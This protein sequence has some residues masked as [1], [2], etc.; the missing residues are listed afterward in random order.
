MRITNNMIQRDSLARLQS[1]IRDVASAQQQVS[2]GLR[3][4]RPSDDPA[5]ASE[6]MRAGGGL[7]VLQQY[8]RNIESA[9]SR[10]AA[11]EGVLDRLTEA[12][13]RAK[14]LGVQEGSGTANAQTRRVAKAEVD[15][16]LANAVSFG[17]TEFAG[18]YLF[19]GDVV[20]KPPFQSPVYSATTPPT[21][22]APGPRGAAQ[23]EIA[24]GQYV[25]ATHDGTQV[26]LDTGAILA[27][28]RLS[29]ALG[30][31]DETKIRQSLVDLDSA[32]SNVQTI[33]GETGARVNQL[34]VASANLDA[35]ETNLTTFKS[36]LEEVDMEKAMTE[37][38]GRQTAYQAAMMATSRVLG[39]NLADYLR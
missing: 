7:R 27:L 8:R 10:A 4:V 31:D 25:A 23:T 38:V 35:L 28:Q 29:E 3:I 22:A 15:Q 36:G 5:S 24:A 13:D 1:T 14:V 33:L 37:L 39:M 30:S 2:G 18:G 11:E 32:F 21:L 20:D 17:N 6:A 26:F 16:L 9:S 12:L 34:Q 19:G